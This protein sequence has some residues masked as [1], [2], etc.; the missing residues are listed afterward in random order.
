MI[1]HNTLL[2]NAGTLSGETR[3]YEPRDVVIADNLLVGSAGSLVAMGKTTGFTWHRRVDPLLRQESDGVFRLSAGS[4]AIGTATLGS[5]S[6]GDDI[7]GHS[8]GT[9]RDI[10]ADEYATPAPLRRPLTAADV[11]PNAS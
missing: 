6:V 9:T 8:R 4:P 10:G 2:G 5:L 1:A 7:D 3:D 11:G